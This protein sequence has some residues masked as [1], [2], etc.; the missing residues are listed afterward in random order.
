MPDEIAVP[1]SNVLGIAWL[2]LLVGSAG[3]VYLFF[4][5]LNLDTFTGLTPAVHD[6]VA[7][8]LA[9]SAIFL[10]LQAILVWAFLLLVAGMAHVLVEIRDALELLEPEEE[11]SAI[12]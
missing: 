5:L 1:H 7:A 11:H 9:G 2:W 3:A 8:L 10:L 4:R 12:M 6:L